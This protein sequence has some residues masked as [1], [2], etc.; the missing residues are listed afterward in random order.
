MSYA[1]FMNKE[2]WDKQRHNTTTSKLDR[3]IDLLERLIEQGDE[4]E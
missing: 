4:E 2:M 3:I 1:D